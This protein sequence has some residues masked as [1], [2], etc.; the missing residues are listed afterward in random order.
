MIP[1]TTTTMTPA[2]PSPTATHMLSLRILTIRFRV[3]HFL[4]FIS[5]SYSLLT[6]LLLPGDTNADPDAFDTDPTAVVSVSAQEPQRKRRVKCRKGKKKRGA[7]PPLLWEVWEEAHE[8]WI[9]ENLTADV[10]LDQQNALITE[11][12]EAPSQLLMP[13]LR[14]QKEWLAWALKQEESAARGGILADEMGMGKTIQAIALVLAK[15]ELLRSISDPEM[16][17]GTSLTASVPMIKSTLV[18]CPVVAVTQWVSEIDRFTSKGS[19]RVVVYHGTNRGKN[20]EDFLDYDFV[21]TTYSIVEAE[22]RKYMMPPKSKCVYCGKS[23]HL[24]KLSTH[25]KYYCG[26]GATRTDKQSKQQRKKKRSAS[27]YDTVGAAHMKKGSSGKSTKH[28]EEEIDAEFDINLDS[29]GPEPRLQQGKSLLHSVM[30]NRIILDE[31]NGA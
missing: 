15:R 25:L 4:T 31:V 17:S 2:S 28:W 20:I 23:Y 8:R 16:F 7:E 26:P 14:Y 22:Y 24:K 13:L 6:D 19:T 29:S 27:E 1:P 5:P 3:P 21:I 11:I 9:D 10:D 18:I 30:W 12:A